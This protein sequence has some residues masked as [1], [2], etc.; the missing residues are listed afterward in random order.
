[1]VI[2]HSVS[3]QARNVLVKGGGGFVGTVLTQELLRRKHRVTFIDNFWF[4]NALPKS[5]NLT[6]NTSDIRELD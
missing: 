6:V 4:G 3:N 1:M 5:P 2:N